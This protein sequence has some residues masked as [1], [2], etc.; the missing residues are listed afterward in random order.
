MI[1]LNVRIKAAPRAAK[2]SGPKGGEDFCWCDSD[3]ALSSWREDL[4][5]SAK[6]MTADI[7]VVSAILEFAAAL[8]IVIDLGAALASGWAESGGKNSIDNPEMSRRWLRL[9]LDF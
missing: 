7:T 5:S 1:R 6:S 8:L 3:E 4:Q 2:A 9:I